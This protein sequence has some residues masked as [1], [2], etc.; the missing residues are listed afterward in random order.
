[1]AVIAAHAGG[2]VLWV[3]STTLLQLQTEDRFRGRVFSAEF[4]FAVLTMSMSSYAAGLLVDRRVPVGHVA[5][6]V[7]LA[8]MI[9]MLVWASVLSRRTLSPSQ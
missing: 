6:W 5:I 9:P 8:V 2:S 7:G 3:F 1:M 4:G